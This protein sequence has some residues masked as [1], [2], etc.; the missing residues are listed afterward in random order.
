MNEALENEFNVDFIYR[1]DKVKAKIIHQFE[2]LAIN[3]L[4]LIKSCLEATGRPPR[5]SIILVE[6]TEVGVQ[7]V[8]RK[9]KGRWIIIYE[10]Q[11]Y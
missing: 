4:K 5:I 2:P 9:E 3:H 6:A 11:N 7:F 10:G 1:D 8:F